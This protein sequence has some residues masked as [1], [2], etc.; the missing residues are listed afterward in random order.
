MDIE[1]GI[2]H[3]IILDKLYKVI[4]SCITMEQLNIGI[5]MILRYH[6]H[7]TNIFLTL[8][9]LAISDFAKLKMKLFI[10]NKY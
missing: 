7:P 6:R 3:N 10:I 5:D 4:D 8:K 2:K 1:T 9:Y